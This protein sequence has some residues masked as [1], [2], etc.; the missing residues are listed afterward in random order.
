MRLNEDLLKQLTKKTSVQ[1]IRRYL[2][3]VSVL[4]C[5]SIWRLCCKRRV[6]CFQLL[7][8][9]HILVLRKDEASVHHRVQ[10]I[11]NPILTVPSSA[12]KSWDLP[13]KRLHLAILIPWDPSREVHREQPCR[14]GSRITPMLYAG[15]RETNPRRTSHVEIVKGSIASVNHNTTMAHEVPAISAKE[16]TFVLIDGNISCKV[17]IVHDFSLRC[18]L[19]SKVK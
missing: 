18:A 11:P 4:K 9:H 12:H 5:L 2:I 15:E 19:V 16:T 14:S 3:I 10:C 1:K 13:Q 6:D 7:L 17:I 8:N